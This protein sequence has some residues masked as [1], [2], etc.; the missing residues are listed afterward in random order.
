MYVSGKAEY[1]ENH[2]W[3]V[4]I[5]YSDF[6]ESN[7]QIPSL[8]KYRDGCIYGSN[9]PPFQFPA[10]LRNRILQQMIALVGNQADEV[11]IESHDDRSAPWGELL[12]QKIDAKH[13]VVLL[14]ELFRGPEKYYEDLIGFYEFKHDRGEVPSEAP[15][16]AL[17][18]GYRVVPDSEIRPFWIDEDPVRDIRN[19]QI[20]SLKESDFD[21][22]ICY[23]GRTEKAYVPSVIEGVAE[24]AGRHPDK[25]ICFLIV[26]DHSCIDA[27]LDQKCSNIQNLEIIKL[28]VLVPI[29]KA[30]F[31]VANV[32]IATGGSARCSVYEDCVTIVPDPET[33]RS[34]GILGYDSNYSST[35]VEG[36]DRHT[37]SEDLERALIEKAQLTK[38]S[39]YPAKRGI[40]NCVKQNFEF[41]AN[42]CQEKTYYDAEKLVSGRRIRSVKTLLKYFL[43]LCFP[44]VFRRIIRSR[45]Q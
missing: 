3:N 19:E 16:R 21:W 41:I 26:G 39:T 30:L 24:F 18:N 6:T 40:E 14:N 12:A 33:Y 43:A 22:S 4:K 5:I 15:L 34:L 27:L 31:Q 23:L 13:I 35:H 1:L 17:L 11:I 10:F 29:P 8:E 7:C 28:G 2:G 9:V 44:A 36:M 37:I 32:I 45:R 38:E 25:S 42:S 20:E